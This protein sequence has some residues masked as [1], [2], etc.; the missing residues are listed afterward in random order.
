MNLRSIFNKILLKP[1]NQVQLINIIRQSSSESLKIEPCV[2]AKV[3]DDDKITLA[4]A[5][6]KQKIVSSTLINFYQIT[7]ST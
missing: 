1:K 6:V 3:D 7:K 5:K 4:R 2:D